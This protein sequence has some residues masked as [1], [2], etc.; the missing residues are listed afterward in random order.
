[1]AKVLVIDDSRFSRNR[2]V[3][4]LRQA[5]HEAIEAADGEQ[6]LAAVGAH[7]PDCIIL[8]MLMPVL[9]GPEFLRRL[10]SGERQPPVI[11]LTA[12]IQ[13]SSQAICAELGARG[14]LNKPLRAEELHRCLEQVLL[15]QEKRSV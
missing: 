11:V 5:S 1:V 9:D 10:R 12:D 15:A 4:A 8:D 2:T 6:G 7:A 3:T 14:F 13:S